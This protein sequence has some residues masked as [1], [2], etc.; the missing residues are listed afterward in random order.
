MV[1]G[2]DVVDERATAAVAAGDAQAVA[3]GKRHVHRR[4]D[5]TRVVIAVAGACIAAELIADAPGLVE[6]RAA[7]GVAPEQGPLRTLQYLNAVE[8]VEGAGIVSDD[9]CLVDIGQYAR[10][11][12]GIG[13]HALAADG[14]VELVGAAVLADSEAGHRRLQVVLRE[15]RALLELLP[16]DRG[17]RNRHLLDTLLAAACGDDDLAIGWCCGGCAWDGRGGRRGRRRRRLRCA[18]LRAAGARERDGGNGA[19]RQDVGS[20]HCILPFVISAPAGFSPVSTC[21]S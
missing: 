3:V 10:R 15:Y 17:D 21:V 9:L 12:V 14:I 5:V 19:E 4:L 1:A 2:G 16:P 11:R 18:V 20:F 13:V 8:I 7:G 6:H